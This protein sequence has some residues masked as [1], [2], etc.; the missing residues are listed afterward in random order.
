MHAPDI[1]TGR[2]F[3]ALHPSPGRVILCAVTGSH[4]YGFPSPDSDLDLKGIHAAPID[5]LL[6]LQPPEES[7]DRLEVFDG[8]EC[9]LTTHE[10]RQALAL[11]LKG[12]GNLIERIFS[13]F[14]LIESPL[15]E[16]LRGLARRTFSRACFGHYSGYFRGVCREHERAPAPT[17][18]G[19]LYIFRVALSGIHLLSTGEPEA[20]LRVLGPRYGYP[21]LAELIE[22]KTSQ[23][24]KA[25]LSPEE[26]ARYR[27]SWPNLLTRLERARD[28]S[29][30]PMEA[31]NR[32]EVNEWLV[33]FR[34]RG[35]QI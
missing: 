34:R 21:E 20:D 22:R 16:E 2:R 32:A 11:L 30:L 35:E 9:D 27:A 23:K 24:E 12:N 5:A 18:K 28:Q 31:S 4:L 10:L 6:G 15:V 14:Q 7:F 17:A 19:M 1:A 13:P 29:P 3:L 33:S 8:V 25:L 26:D